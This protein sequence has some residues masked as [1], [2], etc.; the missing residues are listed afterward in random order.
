[1]S[2]CDSLTGKNRYVSRKI[3]KSLLRNFS[4]GDCVVVVT[5][6]EFV[7]REDVDRSEMAIHLA[8]FC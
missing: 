1:M 8:E 5:S 7:K 4:A 3:V 2:A 6:V